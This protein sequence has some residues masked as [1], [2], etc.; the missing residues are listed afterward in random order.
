MSGATSV[1]ERP[2]ALPLVTWAYALVF[3]L[4]LSWR[5]F[6]H[7]ISDTPPSQSYH[8]F[9]AERL[10][11]LG[12]AVAQGAVGIVLL[13]DS[14]L[15]YATWHDEPLAAAIAERLGRPVHL[16]RLVHDWGVF[17][18]FAPLAPLLLDARPALVVIQ[19]ELFAK[20]RETPGRLLLGRTY[21]L[22][23][24]FGRGPW[25]PDGRD[26][27]TYQDE[28]RCEVL[29]QIDAQAR[30]ERVFLWVGFDPAGA[31]ARAADAFADAVETVGGNVA[32]LSIPITSEGSAILPGFERP[33]DARTLP[34]PPAI[35][36]N[37]FCDVVHM[38]EQ[39]RDRFSRWLIDAVAA[40]LAPEAS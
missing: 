2:K 29:A 19:D 39:G 37:A 6:D 10:T 24:L 18:D 21:L 26:P 38:N 3:A 16:V 8:R 27:A 22:W 14:R 17:G 7:L 34:A 30:K 11:A 35:A 1:I 36:D 9:D 31:N 28:Q 5:L 33:A 20:E 40:R 13:G 4:L 23:Q 12:K 15:R 25:N 32:V